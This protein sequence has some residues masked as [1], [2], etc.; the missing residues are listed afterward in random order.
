MTEADVEII[1]QRGLEKYPHAKPRI[2][3]DNG[4]QF[5]ARDFKELIRIAGLTHVRTSPSYPQSNG[6]IERWHKSLKNDC[7]RPGVP[8]N[9]QEARRLVSGFVEEHYNTVRLHSAIGHITPTDKLAAR[10][11]K[12]LQA[13]ETRKIKRNK[14]HPTH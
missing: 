10:D 1:L 8:L 2:I 7:I 3:S 14:Q 9:L 5:I 13:R 6:K 4:P 12:L 11:Q